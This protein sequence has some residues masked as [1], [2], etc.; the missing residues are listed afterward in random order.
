MLYLLLAILCSAAIA[1][2]MRLSEG[3]IR[4]RFSLLA[5]NYITCTVVA[6]FYTGW[7]SLFPAHEALG[8]TLWL[9]AVNGVLYLGSFWL[10]QTN[11]R[12]SGV[13]LSSLFM[14][15]GLLVPVAMSVLLFRERPGVG[16]A[17]GFVLAVGAI[18]LMN[19][20]KGAAESRFR[21]ELILLLLGGGAADAMSKIFEELGSAALAS[22]FLYYTFQW[23]MILCAAL[24]IWK[25]ERMGWAEVGFGLALGLPNYFSTRFLLLALSDVPAVIAYPTY[26][27]GTIL[28]VA[29]TGILLFRERLTRRQ[30]CA[31]GVI[32]CA[33]ALLNV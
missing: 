14:K 28:A 16:Q 9:G 11:T 12:R 19:L 5:V 6:G 15:L 24:V 17:V 20:Q 22:H 8:Q 32:L 1:P 30:W 13:V 7:D 27:V 4:G 18:L 33:I 10:L 3:H 29:L 23:A 21:P 25:K 26:S 2:V 31:V